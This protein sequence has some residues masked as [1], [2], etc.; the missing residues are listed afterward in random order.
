[1]WVTNLGYNALPNASVGCKL[2]MP[3]DTEGEVLT[4]CAVLATVAESWIEKELKWQRIALVDLLIV[5]IWYS[6]TNA[7]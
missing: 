3:S 2:G 7:Y 1:M 5:K 6:R 4:L